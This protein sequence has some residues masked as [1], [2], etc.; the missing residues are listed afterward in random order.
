[1]RLPTLS[2]TVRVDAGFVTGDEISS[3][4][5][6]MIAK[7]IVRG[8]DRTTA[9][10]KL[11]AALEEYEVVGPSTNIDFLKRVCQHPAFIAGD[12]ETGFI[13]KHREDLFRDVFLTSEVYAQA[14]VG[15]V[16]RDI[17]ATADPAYENSGAPGFIAGFQKRVLRFAPRTLVVSRDVNDIEIE[18]TQTA[19]QEFDI[20]VNGTTY[21]GVKSHWDK[22]NSIL[23][24]FFPHT[25]LDTRLVFDDGQVTAFQQGSQYCLQYALPKWM[26]KA[27]GIKDITNSVLAPMPCK[28]LR[29]MISEGDSVVKDQALVVIESMKMETTI[30]SPQDGI[31]SKVVHEQGVSSSIYRMVLLLRNTDIFQ[32]RS[33]VKPVLL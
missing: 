2:S 19:S 16:L 21:C 26:E 15:T 12:V 20:I 27:M 22:E 17:A 14:A 18:V 8:P 13:P 30:R 24:S 29:V 23:T 28:V 9:L 33:S 3:H 1:M 5:D 6:P 11:S 10:Q 31:V 4:Y 25:R 32:P 7:L